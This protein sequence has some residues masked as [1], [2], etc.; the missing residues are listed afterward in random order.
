MADSTFEAWDADQAD[1]TAYDRVVE[2]LERVGSREDAD[3]E[4]MWNCPAH[5]DVTEAVRA[6]QGHAGRAGGGGYA[7]LQ[8]CTLGANV[9]ETGG[10]QDEAADIKG[11]GLFNQLGR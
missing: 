6:H 4:G 11:G 2:A 8:G 3:R 7:R 1:M 9:G 5:V 10:D